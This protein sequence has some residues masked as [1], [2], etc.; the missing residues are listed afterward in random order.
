MTLDAKPADELFMPP[1]RQGERAP[2]FTAR[3]TL[4]DVSLSDYRG[5]WL[6]LFSHPADFTPV[7]TSE[8]IA[9]AKAKPHFDEMGCELLGLSV[10]GLFSHLAWIR[11]IRDRFGVEVNFP[12]IEDPS[13]AIARGYG[14]VGPDAADSSTARVTYVIDPEGIIRAMSWYPMNIGRSVDELIRLVTALQA[15]DASGASTPEGWVK[16]GA[17]LEPVALSASE[18][19]LV[20]PRAD[21][22]WYFRWRRL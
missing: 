11:D 5:R 22:A 21:E 3:T 1:L 12:I 19:L 9:F 2:E 14:M 10:D 18:A 6:L 7:C 16:G 20:E 4:G 8:F 13:M 15:C 17:M